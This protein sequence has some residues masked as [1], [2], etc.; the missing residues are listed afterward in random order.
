MPD[1]V[2]D[3]MTR[4]PPDAAPLARAGWSVQRVSGA[5]AVAWQGSVEAVFVF[6]GGEWRRLAT[7]SPAPVRRAS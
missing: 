3:R 7:R 5:Y 2:G 4:V 6:R 1:Q